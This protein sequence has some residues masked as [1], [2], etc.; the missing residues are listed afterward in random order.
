MCD[1]ARQIK[2]LSEII[3]VYVKV[4]IVIVTELMLGFFVTPWQAAIHISHGVNLDIQY[5]SNMR[6]A[7]EYCASYASKHDEADARQIAKTV[8]KKNMNHHYFE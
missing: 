8:I 7:G 5:I 3:S 1:F 2:M 4:V 6:G